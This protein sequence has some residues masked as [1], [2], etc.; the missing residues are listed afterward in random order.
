MSVMSLNVLN[1][2]NRSTEGTTTA[3]RI[4]K[5]QKLITDYMPDLIGVQEFA[6]EWITGLIP[7]IMLFMPSLN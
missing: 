2:D 3:E 6:G 1:N 7:I 4:P 5:V